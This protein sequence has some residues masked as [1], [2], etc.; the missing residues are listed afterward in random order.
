MKRRAAACRRIRPWD[1]E[2]LASVDAV[3]EFSI[4]TSTYAPEVWATAGSAGSSITEAAQTIQRSV[5]NYLRNDVF[6]ANNFFDNAAGLSRPPLRQNDFGGTFGGPLPFF[7]FGEG[8]PVLIRA[9]TARFSLSVTKDCACV[10]P[11]G[12]SRISAFRQSA[13]AK[14]R[15]AR[16]ATFSTLFRSR[17]AR[18]LSA[19]TD[20]DRGSSLCRQFYESFTPRRD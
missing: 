15:P 11:D 1:D 8:G 2:Q 9:K 17:P 4:Q 20:S 6:D 7:N 19:Q 10:N 3:Q 13:P 14:T 16:Y 18:K 12:S 5:F